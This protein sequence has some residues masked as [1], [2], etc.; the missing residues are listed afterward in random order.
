MAVPSLSVVPDAEESL[1]EDRFSI[2]GTESDDRVQAFDVVAG[3]RVVL[4]YVRGVQPG[5]ATFVAAARRLCGLKH[6]NIVS[7]VAHGTKQG[8]S[9]VVTKPAH[10]TGLDQL[11]ACRGGLSILEFTPIAAQLL[12]AFG[13]AHSHNVIMGDVRL[14]EVLLSERMRRANFVTLNGRSL[15]RRLSPPPPAVAPEVIA[16]KPAQPV[17]DVY[18]LGTLFFAMLVGRSPAESSLASALP[19]GHKIPAGL[20]G[21]VDRCLATS[22]RQRPIDAN[23]VFEQ[24]IDA[25]PPAFFR[26]PKVKYTTG[27][28]P[29]VSSGSAFAVQSSVAT[30]KVPTAS[31]TA[32]APDGAL[33]TPP[34]PPPVSAE[35]HAAVIPSGPPPAGAS[36]KRTVVLL[37]GVGIAL[38]ALLVLGWSALRQP[39]AASTP[40]PEAAT[41]VV[42][43][44]VRADEPQPDSQIAA[45]PLP[46]LAPDP[47]PG[48]SPKPPGRVDEAA[49]VV[50]EHS[51]AP[52]PATTSRRASRRRRPKAARRP[53]PPAPG[54]SAPTAKPDPGITK[55]GDGLRSLD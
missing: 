13:Y 40:A 44:D 55:L 14:D 46:V 21:L 42:P 39:N 24:L 49:E 29:A 10:G 34:S 33:W 23:A 41:A 6:D 25:V 3:E 50:V 9:F 17:A 45:P 28:N 26:L 48:S 2:S 36:K 12:K 30:P 47:G 8:R 15:V 31:F 16:G 37:L 22:P 35:S 53:A 54:Q 7:F 5:D 38:S 52:A 4:D 43:A 32:V 18:V 19:E 20:V 1:L 27:E 11:V 51:P